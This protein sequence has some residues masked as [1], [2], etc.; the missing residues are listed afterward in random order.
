MPISSPT[1]PSIETAI[2]VEQRAQLKKPPLYKVLIHNDHYTTMDFVVR[3]LMD[4]FHKPENEA[5]ETMWK[6]HLKGIGLAGVYTRE[7]AETKV[8]CAQALAIAHEFP[9]RLSMEPEEP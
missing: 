5:V 4:I 7:I 3:V 9:L 2:E 1:S 8:E 6:V